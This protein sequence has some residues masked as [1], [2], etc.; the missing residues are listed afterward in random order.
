MGREGW[1]ER[2]RDSPEG[3]ERVTASHRQSSP[4]LYGGSELEE[5]TFPHQVHTKLPDPVI[6]SVCVCVTQSENSAVNV[7]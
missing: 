4:A 6:H 3:A 5:R 7:S 1:R 2:E